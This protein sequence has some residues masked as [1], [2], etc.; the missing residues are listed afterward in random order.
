MQKQEQLLDCYNS[1]E[2]CF[3]ASLSTP[4][5]CYYFSM[6]TNSSN[7]NRLMNPLGELAL[8]LLLSL[9]AGVAVFELSNRA[10]DIKWSKCNMAG[11]CLSPDVE[12]FGRCIHLTITLALFGCSIELYRTFHVYSRASNSVDWRFLAALNSLLNIF[13][14]LK[15]VKWSARK[16]WSKS[17]FALETL[18]HS[19]W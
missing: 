11:G 15:T 10:A 14:G 4:C 5:L 7:P 9:L 2:K 1:T 6:F 17:T 3:H 12:N 18:L 19:F 13:L 16:Q 8:L